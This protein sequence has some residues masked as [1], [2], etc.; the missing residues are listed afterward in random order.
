MRT[1]A[2]LIQILD[3]L[4]NISINHNMVNDF[5]VG[6]ID[7]LTTKTR[8]YP[9]MWVDVSPSIPYEA[10]KEY[11]F[12]LYIMDQEQKD[13][14]NRYEIQSDS[15]QVIND[16]LVLFRDVY[17]FRVKW[18][19]PM[20]QF[21]QFSNAFCAGVYM[22]MTVL[23]PWTYG[24]PDVPIKQQVVEADLINSD[25]VYFNDQDGNDLTSFNFQ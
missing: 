5:F 2:T 3:T 13:T 7:E 19:K 10:H 18:G 22:D 12:R 20:V 6:K 25:G 9:L 24:V 15:E 16:I 23:V 1:N 17:D 8:K 11:H 21:E 4:Q 14:S